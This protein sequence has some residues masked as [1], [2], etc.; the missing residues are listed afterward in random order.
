MCGYSPGA[1]DTIL[2]KT[3]L[4]DHEDDLDITQRHSAL[5]FKKEKPKRTKGERSLPNTKSETVQKYAHQQKH[6][7]ET[8]VEQGAETRV[9]Q[10]AETRVG[11]GDENEVFLS[12]YQQAPH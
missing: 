11:H 1:T 4:A 2:A 3:E 6:D 10:G 5:V 12:T 8:R 9:R 7:A